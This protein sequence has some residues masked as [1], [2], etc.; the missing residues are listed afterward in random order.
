MTTEAIDNNSHIRVIV[1][2]TL[3]ILIRLNVLL[4]VGRDVEVD[5]LFM[6]LIPGKH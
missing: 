2:T 3:I 6:L 1:I 5:S 4:N